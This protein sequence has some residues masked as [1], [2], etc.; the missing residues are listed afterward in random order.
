MTSPS[1]ADSSILFLTPTDNSSVSTNTLYVIIAISSSISL[2]LL[3]VISSLVCKSKKNH[4]NPIIGN[5]IY[6][7]SPLAKRKFNSFL[8]S[9]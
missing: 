1:C 5:N 4:P 7:N 6:S 2:L 9:R 3:V 8:G